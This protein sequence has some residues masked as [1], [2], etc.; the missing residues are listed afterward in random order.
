MDKEN[1][2]KIYS[3]KTDQSELGKQ[4]GFYQKIAKEYLDGKEDWET[5][6]SEKISVECFASWLDRR[7]GAMN[8]DE[9]FSKESPDPFIRRP[10]SFNR[11]KEVKTCQQYLSR[12]ELENIYPSHQ[13]HE[14]RVI[15]DETSESE[16]IP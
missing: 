15:I 9:E 2:E 13:F 3:K 7:C 11:I 8:T 4:E 1:Y 16:E 5:D 12:E 10:F 6:P 14:D